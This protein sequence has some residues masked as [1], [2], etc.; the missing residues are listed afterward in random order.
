MSKFTLTVDLEAGTVR[1]GD[2]EEVPLE[3]VNVCVWGERELR[4]CYPNSTEKALKAIWRSLRSIG[5]RG[6]GT[7][8]QEGE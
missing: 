1:L 8:A 6:S 3:A 4:W 5:E 2:G 7:S